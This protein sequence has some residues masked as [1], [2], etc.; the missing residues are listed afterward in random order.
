MGLPLRLGALLLLGLVIRR[1]GRLGIGLRLVPRTTLPTR[2]GVY[3]FL[4]VG[5]VGSR[6]RRR[7]GDYRRENGVKVGREGMAAW[8]KIDGRV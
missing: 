5:I 6:R 7:S 8:V 3:A 4:D 1:R 2:G